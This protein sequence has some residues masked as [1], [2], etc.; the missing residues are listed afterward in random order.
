LSGVD[1][2]A[3]GGAVSFA[4]RSTATAGGSSGWG[5]EGAAAGV[6]GGVEA[7]GCET[8][9]A[10]SRRGSA[11]GAGSG[12]GGCVVVVAAA[13]TSAV[14]VASKRAAPDSTRRLEEP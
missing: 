11:L 10:S 3:G 5:D 12:A 1:G 13:A 8:V 14:R 4:G 9:G 6:T 2:L 7:V